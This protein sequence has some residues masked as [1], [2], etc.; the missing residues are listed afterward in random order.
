M[1]CTVTIVSSLGWP[2]WC[3]GVIVLICLIH[4][5]GYAFFHLLVSWYHAQ[6]M[7]NI[8]YLLWQEGCVLYTIVGCF[9][10]L[11]CA[12]ISRNSGWRGQVLVWKK[13]RYDVTCAVKGAGML[14]LSVQFSMNTTRCGYK[15]DDTAAND[16]ISV[17]VSVSKPRK[18]K[19]IT[20]K[21]KKT[22]S[23]HPKND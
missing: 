8:I 22:G 17:D 21:R 6:Q 12:C 20:Q 10:R 4:R 11:S 23:K 16:L 3:N 14:A 18:E 15:I 5:T 19:K 2:D 9:L 7:H 13:Y 1:L